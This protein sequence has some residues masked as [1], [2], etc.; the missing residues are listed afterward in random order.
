MKNM[1]LANIAEAAGGKLIAGEGKENLE[2]TG[3]ELDSRK[4]Q[5]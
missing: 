1:T 3:A 2:I 4:I 5:K